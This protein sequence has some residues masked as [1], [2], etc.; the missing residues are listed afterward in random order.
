MISTAE[1][2]LNGASVFGPDAVSYQETPTLGIRL[3][4]AV[5]RQGPQSMEWRYQVLPISELASLMSTWTATYPSTEVRWLTPAGE[6]T[7]STWCMLQPQVGRRSGFHAYDV[8]IRF[9][10]VYYTGVGIGTGI[11]S[12]PTIYPGFDVP[13]PPPVARISYSASIVGDPQIVVNVS[14]S[15]STDADGVVMSYTWVDNA[16]AFSAME[17]Y[18]AFETVHEFTTPT[19]TFVYTYMHGMPNPVITLTVTDNAGQTGAASIT[20]DVASLVSSLPTKGKKIVVASGGAYVSVNGGL[21][22][23]PVG[24]VSGVTAVAGAGGYVVIGTDAGEVYIA[25]NESISNAVKVFTLPAAVVDIAVSPQAPTSVAVLAAD[26]SLA[27]STSSGQAFA[28]VTSPL[29]TGATCAWNLDV[30][31]ELGVVGNLV[32]YTRNNGSSWTVDTSGLPGGSWVSS[33][34]GLRIRYAGGSP[35]LYAA[36]GGAWVPTGLTSGV[37]AISEEQGG[38]DI[39]VASGTNLHRVTETAVISTA[40][41][42]VTTHRIAR[43]PAGGGIAMLA[44]SGGLFKTLDNF[45]T[46]GE[47]AFAGTNVADVDF[48]RTGGGAYADVLLP[49]S[50]TVDVAGIWHYNGTAGW[51]R[52]NG[53]DGSALPVGMTWR[54]VV[55]DLFNRNRWVALCNSP[56]GGEYEYSGSAVIC[57]GSSASPISP[58]WITEDA[59]ETWAPITVDMQSHVGHA[60]GGTQNWTTAAI[61]DMEFD[62]RGARGLFVFGSAMAPALT[63]EGHVH[64]MVWYGTGASVFANLLNNGTVRYYMQNYAGRMSS[65]A[66]SFWRGE[67]GP[68]GGII[69]ITNNNGGFGRETPMIFEFTDDAISLINLNPGGISLSID[70]VYT[71]LERRPT[72]GSTA[73]IVAVTEPSDAG[74]RYAIYGTADYTSAP[75]ALL[76]HVAGR[77]RPGYVPVIVDG[78]TVD[79]VVYASMTYGVDALYLGGGMGVA[80]L[81]DPFTSEASEVY[82]PDIFFTEVRCDRQWRAAVAAMAYVEKQIHVKTTTGWSVISLPVGVPLHTGEGMEV[83]G[84]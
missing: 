78:V 14:G 5:H 45:A 1:W 54:K 58:L 40:A 56:A 76:T 18:P 29:S 72:F 21:D 81:T 4:G 60:D 26:G 48:L 64:G 27:L 67:G 51:V 33:Q 23:E 53:V 24:S 49:V 47:L 39:G 44:T 55:A 9:I 57:A 20:V 83:L 30:P 11:G 16:A 50:G 25:A 43:D 19:A 22:F 7:T 79:V 46:A 82:R 6:W 59:G 28:L 41:I 42:G 77:Q 69:A 52:K 34:R 36:T 61:N 65:Q 62:R 66:E 80:M 75:L 15:G 32:A 35:G 17:G 74:W 84:L 3:D 13:N 10:P 68:S 71:Q 70:P 63:G 73:V 31:N 37:T 8:S 12:I 38:N 2:Q